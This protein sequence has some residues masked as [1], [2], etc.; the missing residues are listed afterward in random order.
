MLVT[1]LNLQIQECQ[2]KLGYWPP[3]T[4]SNQQETSRVFKREPVL[5]QLKEPKSDLKLQSV[6]YMLSQGTKLPQTLFDSFGVPIRDKFDCMI[7]YQWDYQVI[8]T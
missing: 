4:Y 3:E 1:S 6:N 7:S 5:V 8:Q 2:A